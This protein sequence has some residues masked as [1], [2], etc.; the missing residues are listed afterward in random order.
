MKTMSLITEIKPYYNNDSLELKVYGSQFSTTKN[1]FSIFAGSSNPNCVRLYETKK[2]QMNQYFHS[3]SVEGF[4]KGVYS[5]SVA[6]NNKFIAVGCGDCSV[7]IIN[8][9]NFE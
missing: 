5:L 8:I 4:D 3:W 9:N 2:G 7:S 1:N 6:P